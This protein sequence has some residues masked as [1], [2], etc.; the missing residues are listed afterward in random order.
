MPKE[1]EINN[2]E[3]KSSVLAPILKYLIYILKDNNIQFETNDLYNMVKEDY[4]NLRLIV[5]KME[6]S[7][8]N[9]VLTPSS[10]LTS[11]NK[12]EEE[13]GFEHGSINFIGQITR[14]AFSD[15]LSL[16]NTLCFNYVNHNAKLTTNT[17]KFI[18]ISLSKYTQAKEEEK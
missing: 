8:I 10:Y 1:F 5:N 15:N 9:G 7:I 4:P 14:T 6:F 3:F 16:L 13:E 12:I 2:P 11:S 17:L 18:E